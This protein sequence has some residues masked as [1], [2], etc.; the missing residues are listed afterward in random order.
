MCFAEIRTKTRKK[1][2][3]FYE[4]F[5]FGAVLRCVNLVDLENAFKK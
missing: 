4:Y 2:D 1:F 5:E 3:D